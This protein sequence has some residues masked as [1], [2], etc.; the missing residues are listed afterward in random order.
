M[1]KRMIAAL[2]VLLVLIL[3]LASCTGRQEENADQSAESQILDTHVNDCV[4]ISQ[5]LASEIKIAYCR[6]TCEKNYGGEV[7]FQP[8]D[9]YVERYE[10]KIGDC[11]IV[12][13]GGDEI[14]YTQALRLVE[15]AGYS[16]GFA[17]GQP[18]YAYHE[19]HFYTIKEAYEANLISKSDVYRIGTIFDPEFA[20]RH[21]ISN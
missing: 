19:G 21:P 20:S 15:V 9:M 11:H 17:S 7:K 5:T 10:G 16:L 13:M 2:T 3:M 4:N 14:L 18:V 8:S 1:K 6:F 12:M